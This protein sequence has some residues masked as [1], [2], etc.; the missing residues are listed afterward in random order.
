MTG[1]KMENSLENPA[2]EEL[3]KWIK[4][5]LDRAVRKLLDKGVIDS[6]IVE[7]KPAWVLPFQILIGKIRAQDQT[8]KFIWFICGQVPTDYLES[9][10]ASTPRETARHF[11][12]Q[13]QLTAARQLDKTGKDTSG[14]SSGSQTKKTGMQLVDHAE[15]LYEVVE[16]ERLW[17]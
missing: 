13:W 16:E 9:S 17:S 2:R 12:M 6:L 8:K 14:D 4:K 10:A 5:Q 1:Y 11:A 15:A 7:A 3:S